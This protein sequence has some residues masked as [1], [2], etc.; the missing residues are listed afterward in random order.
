MVK[1]NSN[2]N[3][4]SLRPACFQHSAVKIQAWNS[5]KFALHTSQQTEITSLNFTNIILS[6]QHVDST[7]RNSKLYPARLS[8]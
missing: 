6:R 1:K 2:K 5:Y 8:L 7:G 3:H 4:Y